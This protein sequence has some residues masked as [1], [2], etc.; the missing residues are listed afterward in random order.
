MKEEVTN[1]LSFPDVKHRIRWGEQ[2]DR[3]FVERPS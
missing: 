3:H 1:M 2:T